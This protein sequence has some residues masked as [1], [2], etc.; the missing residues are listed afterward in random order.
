M[1]KSMQDEEGGGQFQ[2]SSL[3]EGRREETGRGE[4][5][6]MTSQE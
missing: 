4:Q 6:A 2:S 1:K 3:Q 5:Q